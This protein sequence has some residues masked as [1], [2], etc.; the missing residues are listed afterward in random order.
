[1]LLVGVKGWSAALVGVVVG[2]ILVLLLLGLEVTMAV[3]LVMVV[4]GL[5]LLLLVVSL[6]LLLDEV[7][8]LWPVT[9]P[10]VPARVVRTRTAPG[11]LRVPR[12]VVWDRLTTIPFLYAPID[13]EV[14]V[15]GRGSGTGGGGIR[16]AL[17]GRHARGRP[18]DIQPPIDGEG[19]S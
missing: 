18:I 7:P 10:W 14:A 13:P 6:L 8:S 15:K 3:A 17:I 12:E 1:M 5:L 11:P 9:L 2:D 19:R 4:V 16:W